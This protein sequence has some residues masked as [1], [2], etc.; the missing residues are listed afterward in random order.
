MLPISFKNAEEAAG[1]SRF[2]DLVYYGRKPMT[3]EERLRYLPEF[4]VA[5]TAIK[6]AAASSHKVR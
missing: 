2:E 3:L 6:K 1:P 5:M 4:L